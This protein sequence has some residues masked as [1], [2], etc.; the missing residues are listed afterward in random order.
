[1]KA[2]ILKLAKYKDDKSFYSKYPT[3]D[4]FMKVHGKAFKKLQLEKALNGTSQISN[5]SNNWQNSNPNNTGTVNSFDLTN[6]WN[7][8]LNKDV[9][10]QD[11]GYIPMAQNGLTSGD[12]Y[13]NPLSPML[14][15]DQINGNPNGLLPTQAFDTKKLLPMGNAGDSGSGVAGAMPYIQAGTDIAQ[16]L[17]MIKGERN[18]VKDAKAQA[19]VSALQLQAARSKNVD[20]N[21]MNQQLNIRPEDIQTTGEEFF[22][23][24]G[25]G[26]NVL[27][28]KN[29]RS[30]KP[31][32]EEK[33]ASKLFS[34]PTP[35]DLQMGND[36]MTSDSAQFVGGYRSPKAINEVWPDSL[37][38]NSPFEGGYF[39]QMYDQHR[40]DE[41][42]GKYN[43][44]TDKI[45]NKKRD[46]GEIQNTYAPNDLYQDLG[47]EPLNDSDQ[48]KTFWGG[49]SMN[50]QNSFDNIMGSNTGMDLLGKGSQMLTNSGQGPDA[51][52]MIGGGIG[53][54]AGTFFGGPLGGAIGKAAGS[55]IG[56]AI[57][58][59]DNKISKYNDQRNRNQ[60]AADIAQTDWSNSYQKD[61]GTTSSGWM[62]PNYNPQL[63][64]KFGDIDVTDLHNIAHQGMDSLRTGGNIR[65][66]YNYPQDE[67]AMDGLQVYKGEAEPV[68]T[69]P[70]L[71]EGGQSVMFRGPSHDNGG[72]PI[73]YGS[74][75]V[76]VEGGEPAVKLQDG[77]DTGPSLTVFGNLKPSRTHLESVGLGEFN[78]QK[79]KGMVDKLTKKTDKL[80]TLV[81]K[82]TDKINDHPMNTSFDKIGFDSWKA[83]LMGANMHLKDIAEKTKS[84]AALQQAINDT[85]DEH[86]IVADD[87]AR[88][89]IKKAKFGGK[90]TAANG[91][92][93]EDRDYL[94]KLYNAAQ[95]EGK[96]P[97]VEKFQTEFNRLA[98]DV[99]K[100]V[101]SKEPTTNYGKTKGL[102]SA[103]LT[104]N[105]DSIFG[106]RTE[107]Y[108]TALDENTNNFLQP[109][110][111]SSLS[112]TPIDTHTLG[113]MNISNTPNQTTSQ[114]KVPWMD[115]INAVVPYLR[116]NNQL[117]RPDLT[118]E[119]MA[120]G[121]NNQE[122]VQAR[123]FQPQLDVPYDISY[124]D[125]LNKN[126]GDIRAAERMYQNNPAFLAQLN[127]QKYSANQQVLG[128]QFR[129]NQNEKNQVY[130]QNRNTLN[131]AQLT[132]LGIMDKQ[133]ERQTSAKVK[134]QEEA[135]N[136]SKSISD[137]LSRYKEEQQ[138]SNLE[139]QRYN[140]RFDNNG[141]P[142]NMNPFAQFNPAGTPTRTGGGMGDIPSDWMMLRDE[143]GNFQGTKRRTKD[144]NDNAKNG[145][146][147]I[148]R[149]GSIVRALKTI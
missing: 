66:N 143:Q 90:F 59:T 74:Q 6:Q 113:K 55:F 110:G 127:A 106:K 36:K 24:N 91:V 71:P 94:T 105:V 144:P 14:R 4:A 117:D 34:Y 125:I 26:T 118:P 93:L 109:R 137:K 88:G 22:P 19:D 2:E 140:Y 65:E 114:N 95:K 23:I 60:Q 73:K 30:I 64:T 131:Q 82:S 132:N 21:T 103:D 111:I 128:E 67:F 133:Y 75:G 81:D 31:S 9:V 84:A 89:Q 18:K 35:N 96:G 5:V 57:D 46:G 120:M 139:Q 99:A 51:G 8:T 80:N 98:P 49:G 112:S 53:A 7:N 16:G 3:E 85:A 104:S 38:I 126:Q 141:R 68:S 129:Q 77:G 142:I 116:P 10:S 69:N 136:I 45:I 70:Y 50:T 107:Q 41:L 12:E 11:A 32:F 79:F 147:I 135:L 78:G 130:N 146:K 134:T 58:R 138:I 149:N 124:Q 100:S 1:M 25:V 56:G 33:K 20:A 72:M 123:Q 54:A 37:T 122:P 48:M 17:S 13:G 119:M 29:G 62:N 92:S 44:I 43:F 86:G 76:E 148:A 97:A 121:F 28:S 42:P 27:Q 40:L 101:L 102:T 15:R 63:I 115:A 39:N 83:N 47:F 145:K 108:K 52:S 61:G 87:L